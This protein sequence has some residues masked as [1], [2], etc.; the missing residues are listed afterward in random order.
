MT[1]EAFPLHSEKGS[2]VRFFPRGISCSTEVHRDTPDPGSR[3]EPT[4]GRLNA[5]ERIQVEPTHGRLYQH[6]GLRRHPAYSLG[7][8]VAFA[9]L[10]KLPSASAARYANTVYA[11]TFC[12]SAFGSIL[13]NVSSAVWCRW[14]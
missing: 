5:P 10:P 2:P 9:S 8:T 13:S 3:V 12:A 1:T 11:A 6:A 7:G 4:H 14:K